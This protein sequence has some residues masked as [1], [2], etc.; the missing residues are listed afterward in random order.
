[1]EIDTHSWVL[2]VGVIAVVLHVMEEYTFGWVAWAN[3][4]LGS[5]LG[6][7]VKETDFMLASLGLVFIAL[8]GAAIGW[9][10]PALSLAVP[11]LFVINAVFFHM[12]PSARA[13]R[14]TPGTFSA[15][16]IYLPV[17]AWMFWAAGTDGRL[18]FGTFVLAFVIAAAIL[19]Y[20]IL[21]LWLKDRIGW[22]ALAPADGEFAEN[23]DREDEDLA[24]PPDDDEETVIL[25]SE[26]AATEA[27]DPTT[28]L[29]RD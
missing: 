18:N 12:L 15:V 6:V 20:P 22:Q 1:M 14:V 26:D 28:E 19:A 21:L 3:E 2:W 11:A 17:A 9:W 7:E 16:V 5:R 8:A 13:D 23:H 10:A 27:D 25:R 4:E 29:R 24:T